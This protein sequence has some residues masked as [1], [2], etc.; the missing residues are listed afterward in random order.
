MRVESRM[1]NQYPWIKSSIEFFAA[2]QIT[3]GRQLL[4]QMKL[5]DLLD[6]KRL[7]LTEEPAL[8]TSSRTMTKATAMTMT[9]RDLPE[10]N[11]RWHEPIERRIWRKRLHSSKSL[12]SK[13]YPGRSEISSTTLACP[14]IRGARGRLRAWSSLGDCDVVVSY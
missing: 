13:R 2:F 5:Q 4:F 11:E 6:A 9:F 8:Q 1:A 12:M 10:S 14:S 3:Q 7:W